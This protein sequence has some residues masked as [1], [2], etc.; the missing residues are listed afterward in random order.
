MSTKTGSAEFETLLQFLKHNRSF[1]FTGY[2][3][4]TLERRITKRM[5]LVGVRD[6]TQYIDYLEVQPDEFVE[7][8]N[9][10]LINVTSFFRD[11][12]A[13]ESL[14]TEALPGIL[15]ARPLDEPIRVWSAGCASGQEAYTIA[16]MLAEALGIEDFCRRVKIYGTDVDEEAL[17]QARSAVYSENDVQEMPEGLRERYFEISEGRATLRSDVRRCVVFGRHDLVQDAPIS[18][19]DLLVCRNVLMYFN[20]D[21]QQHIASRFHFGLQDTGVLFLGKAEMMITRGNL[22]EPVN[23]RSRIFRKAVNADVRDRQIALASALNIEQTTLTGL[24]VDHTPMAIMVID[25]EGR[26]VAANKRA[27]SYFHL[28]DRDNGRAFQDL[29]VSYRPLEVRS[30]IAE[31]YENQHTV[32]MR[33]VEARLDRK[34]F[35]FDV[36]IIPLGG[37]PAHGIALC[38]EDVTH[39][40][41][42]ENE[43]QR[44]NSELETAYEELQ[45]ANEELE[46]TNEEL[47]SAIE[48]LETTN[49]ELQATNE[50]LETMNEE[51]HSTNEELETINLELSRR[52]DELNQTQA[53]T[54][55]IL[56]SL[57]TGLVVLDENGRVRMWNRAASNLW[58]L[59]EDEAIGER[60]VSLDIGLPVKELQQAIRAS[61]ENGAA[62]A[63]L[64]VQA[65]N[66][67]GRPMQTRV[68]IAPY[69]NADKRVRGVVLT[70]DEEHVGGKA[71]DSS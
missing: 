35:V 23:L 4:S 1:D 59:R 68:V 69:V 71:S 15:A 50:E 29:E 42:L 64:V 30:R 12:H 20:A 28:T 34:S 49:E 6:Y 67:R 65:T 66:R 58:G 57:R 62:P 55:A 11:A 36:S 9:T 31:A 17:S 2:K 32:L 60:F 70:M 19:L 47:Q 43:L 63:E 10:I 61:A 56:G 8:F 24:A 25:A 27:R 14:R 53:N 52:T 37:N 45:S 38:F 48:E 51:L 46:T 21:A 13:W 7:L 39:Y 3:R 22:F 41:A 54:N 44:A 33:G 5:E 18:R 26:L 40:H 16:I